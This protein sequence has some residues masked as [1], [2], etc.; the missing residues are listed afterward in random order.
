M[1]ARLAGRLG[2]AGGLLLTTTQ[3][4]GALTARERRL[5]VGLVEAGENP[6]GVVGLELR[7]EVDPAVD[8]VDEAVQAL[9]RA[10]VGAVGGHFQDIALASRS[11][12]IRLPSKTSSGFRDSPL[13]ATVCTLGA[14]SSMNAEAPGRRHTKRT[15]VA[16]WKVV[17]PA[18]RS[19]QT[20]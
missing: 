7:V 10:G 5:E 15:T 2:A 9:A 20:P 19:S 4:S 16:E 1:T 14:V 17:S 13:R 3:P 12:R 8:G 6:V 11:S 18:V